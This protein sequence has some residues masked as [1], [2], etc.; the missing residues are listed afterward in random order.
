MSGCK[1]KI[2]EKL[3]TDIKELRDY[4]FHEADLDANLLQTVVTYIKQMP[5]EGGCGCA[6]VA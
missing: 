2:V 3:E 1:D 6:A 5:C 4:R